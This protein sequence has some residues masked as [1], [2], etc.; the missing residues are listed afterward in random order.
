[1]TRLRESLDSLHLD[2]LAVSEVHV[3]VRRAGH[4]LERVSASCNGVS[5]RTIAESGK[6]SASLG[7][8]GSLVC[9]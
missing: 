5:T 3:D 6:G 8:K 7:S 2:A 1:M 4:G 9:D